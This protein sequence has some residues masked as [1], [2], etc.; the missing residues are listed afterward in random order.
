MPGR[1]VAYFMQR[2]RPADLLENALPVGVPDDRSAIPKKNQKARGA[3]KQD[4][5][6]KVGK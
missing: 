3:D 1:G 2:H 6:S 5:T 4:I